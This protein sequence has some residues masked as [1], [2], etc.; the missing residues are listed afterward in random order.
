MVAIVAIVLRW[1]LPRCC[2]PLSGGEGQ[3]R[4]ESCKKQEGEGQT[5]QKE[6]TIDGR[7][8]AKEGRT[9]GQVGAGQGRD[10]QGP[11][12]G[13]R[14]GEEYDHKRNDALI[15]QKRGTSESGSTGVREQ[16]REWREEG[17]S[18]RDSNN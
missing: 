8:G 12:G 6:R 4:G 10:G 17:R 11:K 2:G 18:N 1:W 14:E 3:V 13:R 7:E 9:D 16:V 5:G 15:F